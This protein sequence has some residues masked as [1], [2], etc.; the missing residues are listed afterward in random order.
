MQN[1]EKHVTD[2]YNIKRI[3]VE[4]V[5]AIREFQDLTDEQA[6]EIA[7]SVFQY[8]LILNYYLHNEKRQYS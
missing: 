5:K 4:D 7:E 1:D 3:S 6:E 8:S 2:L